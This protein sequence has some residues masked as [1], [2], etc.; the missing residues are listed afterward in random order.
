[1]LME[2]GTERGIAVAVVQVHT[3]A[4]AEAVPAVKVMRKMIKKEINGANLLEAK[5]M[6]SLRK[7]FIVSFAF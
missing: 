6:F 4:K 5:G 1:M 2:K 3:T 7:L